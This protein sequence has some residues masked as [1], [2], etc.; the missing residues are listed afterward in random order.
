MALIGLGLAAS[1]VALRQTMALLAEQRQGQVTTI[2]VHKM[3][4]H[5][6]DALLHSDRIIFAVSFGLGRIARL[7]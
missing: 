1:M 6:W 7:I 4:L 2:L 5:G 3:D